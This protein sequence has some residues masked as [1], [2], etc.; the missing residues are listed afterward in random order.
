MRDPSGA[1][2]EDDDDDDNDNET[3]ESKYP[4]VIVTGKSGKSGKRTSVKRIM[5][6]KGLAGLWEPLSC[7]YRPPMTLRG[8]SALEL[9][10]KVWTHSNDNVK[11][12]KIDGGVNGLGFLF[13]YDLFQGRQRCKII[14]ST[15]NMWGNNSDRKTD[16]H[17]FAVLLSQLYFDRK[18]K[19]LL[20][21]IVNVMSR[22]KQACQRLPEFK[23]TR[24][25]R[26][27]NVFVGWT[28]DNEPFSPLATLCSEIVPIMR[29]MRRSKG[30]LKEP[31]PPPYPERKSKSTTRIVKQDEG[32]EWLRPELSDFSKSQ[33]VLHD[34]GVNDLNKII[35]GTCYR[36]KNKNE[37]LRPY[38]PITIIDALH[39]EQILKKAQN[40]KYSSERER[41][42]R[43]KHCS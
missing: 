9:L 2:E 12:E 3:K 38:P 27:S 26:R 29:H 23:D 28:D 32:R 7:R 16:S 5:V 6:S 40:G 18:K 41:A 36:P 21:S 4:S 14:G 20:T 35:T 34:V 39:L 17:R 1:T 25:N 22:N 31:P 19:G 43:M 37:G 33:M 15:W 30:Q 10:Q 42:S 13:L 24:K 11:G 8:K